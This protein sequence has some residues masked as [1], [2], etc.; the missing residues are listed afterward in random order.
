MARFQKAIEV[1]GIEKVVD[2][3]SNK[4]IQIGQWFKDSTTGQRGQYLGLTKAGIVV[5]SWRCSFKRHNQQ[6]KLLRKFALAN[7]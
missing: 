5:M 7:A 1:N 4:A 2:F 3:V 6:T